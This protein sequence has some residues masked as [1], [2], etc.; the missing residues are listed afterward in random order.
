MATFFGRNLTILLLVITFSALAGEKNISQITFL[1]NKGQWK[2]EILF[3][4]TSISPNVYFLKDGL[5]FGISGEEIENE[6]EGEEDHP[7]LVWNMKFLNPDHNLSVNGINAKESVISYLSGNDPT[8]WV[9]HPNEYTEIKYA[10][11]FDKVDLHFYG[12]GNN[13]KYDYIVHS[14]ASITSIKSYYA[15]VKKILVNENGEL[16]VITD[17]HTQIQKAPVAW[18]KINGKLNPVPVSYIIYNDSTFGFTA[19]AGYNKNFDLVIDPLF[20]M[21][22]SS[23]TKATGTTNNQNY[24]FSNAMDKEGNVYLTGMVDGTFPITPGAYSGAGTVSPEIFVAKFSSDGT[25]LIYS[26]YLP[27]N[28]SEHGVAIAVDDSGRAYLTGIIDLNITG[29]TNY[30]STPNA[31]QP[32]H[33]QGSDAFLTVLNPN[34]TGLVY[35]SFLGGTGSETGYDVVLGPIGIAYV[36]GVTSTGNFPTKATNIF[37]TGDQDLFVSKFDI[38]QSG[39]NS[40]IYSTRIGAGSFSSC[41]AKSIDVNSAGN[42]FITGTLGTSFGTP[43]YPTTPGAY[44][45]VYNTGQDNI[46]SFVTKLSATTPVSLDYSTLLAPGIA[47][48]ISV[49][50]TSGDAFIA[51]STYTFAFPVTPGVIQSVHGGTSGTDAFVV[52]M[53]STGTAL[54]YSTF[55]GGE[56]YEEASGIV[57]NS[58]GEAYVTGIAQD[59]FPVSAGAIQTSN[60]GTYDFFV[61]QLNAT[62]TAYGC[63]GSTYIGGSDADYSGSFYDYSSPYISLRDHNGVNDTICVSSTSHSQD[64]PTTPGVYGPVKVNSTADQPVFFKLTCDNGS[65]ALPIAQ[66]SSPD[67][68]CPGT[69][70]NFTNLSQNATSFQWSFPG[71]TITF[72]T[73][74]NP[75]GI[76]YVNPG[77]YD[78]TLIA[79]GSS[80]S[81]TISISN[82]LTV[83]P[84]P[85]PQ[86]I[87][88]SGDTL[89][90]NTGSAA[91]QWYFNGNII[92]GATNY[93]YVAPQSGNYSVVAN[94]ENN[95]EVEAVINNVVAGNQFPVATSGLSIFPNPVVDK[96]EI[97]NYKNDK[98]ISFRI[99]D[100]LGSD[101]GI[102]TANCK[103]GTCSIDVTNLSSG[104]YFL[105]LITTEKTFRAKFIKSNY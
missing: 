97:T 66:F 77:S 33:D 59:S 67:S 25:T 71:A 60:A 84:V 65:A 36:A 105:E 69:C 75:S 13:L 10:S 47:N 82:Y 48:C 72:S 16:E 23:Y 31:F 26:T 98:K 14:A 58:S 80:G 45:T 95:C 21:V 99:Y 93:F 6:E 85:P 28:S 70:V 101:V 87:L 41:K 56:D 1:E 73:D 61:V 17:E 51:G 89:V 27:G 3:Q 76:C 43:T 104:I 79:T 8:K 55:L 49:H 35:S 4:A 68:I 78:V 32:V 100:A 50:N 37:P 46:M 57:V 19:P 44:Q 2:K 92:N 102:E 40:L 22:W 86:G 83:Y 39:N 24:C 74:T 34:G 42:V 11:V 90:A 64:F 52:R 5:S 15:G 18:Q 7:Y 91:Y 96:L 54:V 103:Q 53:N 12:R 30:P 38:N 88:Q 94:D 81:D 20:S 63:G 62:A 29:V 9:I